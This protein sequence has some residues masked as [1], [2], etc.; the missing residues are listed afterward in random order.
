[1]IKD[2]LTE[3]EHNLYETIQKYAPNYR[4]GPYQHG[5]R[6]LAGPLLPIAAIGLSYVGIAVKPLVSGDLPSAPFLAAIALAGYLDGRRGA[7]MAVMVSSI[8]EVLGRPEV[9]YMGRF[10]WLLLCM[11]I[12]AGCSPSRGQPLPRLSPLFVAL[13]ARARRH[14]SSTKRNARSSLVI[15]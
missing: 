11:C 6:V 15:G 10:A 14:V 8:I 5:P 4:P 3:A 9:P 12:V 1:M 2:G 13:W 7:W